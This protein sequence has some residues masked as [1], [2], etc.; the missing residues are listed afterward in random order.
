MFGS[1]YF[2]DKDGPIGK[3][4]VLAE[5]LCRTRGSVGHVH[6]ISGGIKV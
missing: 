3:L 5:I 2:F 1:K 4:T 6:L